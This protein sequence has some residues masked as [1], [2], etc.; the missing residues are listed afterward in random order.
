MQ[1]LL[2][3]FGALRHAKLKVKV[4]K[5]QIA[6]GSIRY[7]GHIVG[8]GQHAPD[9]EK[10]AAIKGLQ[11]PTT[12]RELRSVLGLCGYY[13]EYVRNYAE[14]ARPLTELTRKRGPNKIPWPAEA[15]RAFERLK[16]AL[17]EATSLGTPDPSKPFWLHAD[18]SAFAAGVCLSQRNESGV[19]V[20]IAFASHRF[21]PTQSRWSTIEREAFAVIWGLKKSDIWFFGAPVTVVS[22]HNPLSFLTL[23]A[24]PGAK[25]T[26]W[27]LALQRYNVVVQHRKGS[28]HSNADA[29]SRLRNSCWHSDSGVRAGAEEGEDPLT[30]PQQ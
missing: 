9:P 11:A 25:L 3:I 18:A 20:P 13:R 12:K 14:M 19:E 8:S 7:L 22:D 17:C 27:A 6:R 24:P 28:L 4:E 1:Q 29:L 5:C 23:S 15:E 10:L 2:Q 26:R 30:H 21:S 16:A